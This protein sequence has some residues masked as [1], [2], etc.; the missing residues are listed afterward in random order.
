MEPEQLAAAMGQVTAVAATTGTSFRDV[1]G[2]AAALSL[3]GLP[4]AEAITTIRQTLLAVSAPGQ[5]ARETLEKL[6]S[7]QEKVAA[8]FR[9]QGYLKGVQYLVDLSSKAGSA[10]GSALRRILQDVQ[11]VNAAF[12]LTGKNAKEAQQAIAEVNAASEKDL[13]KAFEIASQSPNFSMNQGFALMKRLMIEIGDT[14]MPTLVKGVNSLVQAFDF[15]REHAGQLESALTAVGIAGVAAFLMIKRAAIASIV[16]DVAALA[17]E[18]VGL[19]GV[20]LTV[21]SDAGV[22]GAAMLLFGDAL[23]ATGIGALVVGLGALAYWLIEA[24][25]NAD[26]TKSGFDRMSKSA[27]DGGAHLRELYDEAD[28]VIKQ[29]QALRDAALNAGKGMDAANTE[30]AKFTQGLQQLG[31]MAQW[32]NVQ[33]AKLALNKSLDAMHEAQQEAAAPSYTG[34]PGVRGASQKHL[35]DT[36]NEVQRRSRV[37]VQASKELEAGIKP[38]AAAPT[39][40]PTPTPTGDVDIFGKDKKNGSQKKGGKSEAERNWEDQ[41]KAIQG[42]LIE[43]QKAN[44]MALLMQGN[45]RD[46]TKGGDDF[47][48]VSGMSEETFQKVSAEYDALYDKRQKAQEEAIKKGHV[49]S[50]QQLQAITLTQDEKTAIDEKVKASMA[51]DHQKTLRDLRLEIAS[52]NDETR[53][54]REQAKSQYDLLVIEQ[55]KA[56][57]A[58][59]HRDITAEDLAL[60]KQLIDANMSN[61]RAKSDVKL[62]DA[63][64]LAQQDTAARMAIGFND[65]NKQQQISVALWEATYKLR[66]DTG[67]LD[68]QLSP[69]ERQN[70]I[71]T[72]EAQYQLNQAQQAYN[73]KKEEA[74]AFFDAFASFFHDSIFGAKSLKDAF[75][76]L[77]SAVEDLIWQ[78]MILL[79]LKRAFEQSS[80]GGIGGIFGAISSL[81][82]GAG[83]ASAAGITV[84]GGA[85][86]GFLPI[87]SAKGNVIDKMSIF[88]LSGGR[89]GSM[90]ED[91]PE[92]IMPL[93]R[94]SDG[95]LGIVSKGGGHTTFAPSIAVQVTA[96]EGVDDPVAFGKIIGDAIDAKLNRFMEKQTRYGG[97]LWGATS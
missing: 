13:R 92:A 65:L 4:A 18:L 59:E 3:N 55:A 93:E 8:V 16:A 73:D 60:A 76:S 24:S 56:L 62:A 79:P 47:A 35:Q 42:W 52:V 97:A 61:D 96:P 2:A 40:T 12:A 10:Q 29:E 70:I 78:Y 20:F 22:A 43:A 31:I 87:P 6:G 53:I 66:Q 9:D 57:A 63:A 51:E 75:K 19:A 23:V 21:A 69:Q 82:G 39:P 46:V 90:A 44:D 91:G 72:T 38:P 77:I 32:T 81:F 41:T 30:A 74:M 83:A 89:T 25:K 68:A 7:S 11:A 27:S 5:Q 50:A 85:P 14:V 84:T 37:L 34:I 17:T 33:V 86:A 48:V 1:A 26:Y 88:P 94:M 45:I 80:G 49:L 71:A 36:I 64:K 15:A 67:H 28:Q 95:R 54:I 58:K